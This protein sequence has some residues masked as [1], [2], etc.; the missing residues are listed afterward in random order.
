MAS[1]NY[2]EVLGLTKGASKDDIKKAFH[3]LAHKYH[4]D[5]AGG[6]EAKF[7][8][9]NEAYG[10]LSDDK[11]RAEYDAYGQTFGGGGEAG[12]GP[13]WNMGNMWQGGAGAGGVEFDM[14]SFGDMFS[15]IFGGNRQDA[16][17]GRD[18]AIDITISFADS[19]FGTNRKVVI[20]KNSPCAMCSG[21]GAAP[22]SKKK[23]CVSC[24][25]RGRIKETSRSF[26]GT[27]VTEK[28]C[29][30][31]YG[32]GTVPEEKCKHC[33]GDGVLRQEEEISIAIPAGME[34]GEMIRISGKG[35]FLRGGNAGDL[36]V[37]VHVENKTKF[38]KE[39]INI[40]TSIDIKL[41]DAILGTIY[42]MDTLDGPI[43]L[44]IPSGIS[45]GEL[46]RVKGRGFVSQGR[47]GDLIVRVKIAMPNKISRET[48]ALLEKLREEG[49]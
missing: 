44:K 23:N 49:I 13:F 30:A 33:H 31:C 34:E 39:G 48:R 32:A 28:Q 35:E 19:V 11:K 17:R 21:S 6:D 25:G 43:E 8:E 15:D 47:R 12:S 4:P 26:L 7:K 14:S 27:F 22:T 42:K 10:V 3:K 46:L 9:I 2:Y 41:T 20:N 38:K 5:K 40:V 1:K 16:R 18:I 37:K 29:S 45:H 36:Y 24:N